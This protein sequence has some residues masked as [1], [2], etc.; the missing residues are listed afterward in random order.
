MAGRRT[1]RKR[2]IGYRGTWLQVRRRRHGVGGW[3][4]AFVRFVGPV[5]WA[6][7]CATCRTRG[8][9]DCRTGFSREGV[10]R[11][12]AKFRQSALASSRLK[13]VP[14]HDRVHS[15]GLPPLGNLPGRNQVNAALSGTGFSREGVNRFAAISRQSAL[16]SSRLKPVPL[17]DS[18]HSRGSP[19]LGNLLGGNWLNAALSGTGFSRE[20]VNRFAAKF[21]LSALASSRLKPVALH[22]SVHSRGSPP[23]GNLPGGN[24]LNAALSGTGFSREG[25]RQHNENGTHSYRLFPG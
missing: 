25:V 14:L 13:P 21:R 18:V 16:A 19:P 11:F 2:V 1:F 3:C 5:E 10:N 9:L 24:W 12:A 17:H 8:D 4:R 6:A 7:S 23:L 15:R 20:G 22:D